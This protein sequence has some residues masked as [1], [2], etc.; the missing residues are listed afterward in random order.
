V[1]DWLGIGL[2]VAAGGALGAVYFGGL[3]LTV[4]RLPGTRHPG[5]WVAVSFFARLAAALAGFYLVAQGGLD[6][7]AACAAAFLLARQV[8]MRLARPGPASRG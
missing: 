5:A 6:R 4:R 8:F 2:A 7:L 1:I 3:W